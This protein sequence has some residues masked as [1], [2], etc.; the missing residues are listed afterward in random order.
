M[1]LLAL[2]LLLPVEIFGAEIAV[3]GH[4]NFPK[5]KLTISE[6]KK[7][8]LGRQTDVEG[9]QVR[10]LDQVDESPAKKQFIR[11][12]LGSSLGKYKAHWLKLIFREG[13]TPPK[14]VL[15]SKDVLKTISKDPGTI[16]YLQAEEL[17]KLEK[18][19]LAEELIKLEG[20]KVLLKFSTDR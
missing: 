9:T 5:D 10:P 8:Y 19:I 6:L 20:I 12:I 7:V 2:L 13:R 17:I 1:T 16:G 4:K 14:V 3:I 18:I 15:T 11:K